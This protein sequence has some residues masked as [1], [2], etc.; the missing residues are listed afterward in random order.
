M[1]IFTIGHSNRDFERLVDLLI[2]GGVTLLADIRRFPRSR[3]NPQFNGAALEIALQTRG[4]DYTHLEGLGGMRKPRADSDNQ[5]LA[6]PAFRGYA[7]YMQTAAFAAEL[8]HLLALAQNHFVAVMCAE[9][10]PAHCHRSLLADVLRARG[11]EV[12]HLLDENRSEPH[13]P[14]G[15]MELRDGRPV[16]PFTLR[17]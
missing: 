6:E 16:Y 10:D 3:R 11:V 13:R 15:G 4:I 17:G 7:D 5:G 2:A 14:T 8:R 9:A 12:M 1:R